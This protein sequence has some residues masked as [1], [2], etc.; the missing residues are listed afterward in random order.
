M[1]KKYKNNLYKIII[2]NINFDK[3]LIYNKGCE[4][5]SYK[6]F[7][8]K[9]LLIEYIILF[10]FRS[11]KTIKLDIKEQFKIKKNDN[12]KSIYSLFNYFEED[13]NSFES[14]DGYQKPKS[15]TFRPA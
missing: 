4:Y 2:D 5:K 14:K 6:K 7:N 15:I 12:D 1:T 10:N 8:N 13:C 11:L 9:R 3:I